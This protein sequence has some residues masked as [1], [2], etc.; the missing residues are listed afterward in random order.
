M[1]L[2]TADKEKSLKEDRTQTYR[3]FRGEFINSNDALK[4]KTE[5]FPKQ[6]N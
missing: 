6:G 4:Q 1:N 3:R 5:N 2:K